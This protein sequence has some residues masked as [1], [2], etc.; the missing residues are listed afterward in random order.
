MSQEIFDT[1]VYITTIR[2]LR[3]ETRSINHCKAAVDSYISLITDVQYQVFISNLLLSH[4]EFRN[5]QFW[6][7]NIIESDC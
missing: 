3:M 7:E 1:H 6:G 5:V 4:L 2:S